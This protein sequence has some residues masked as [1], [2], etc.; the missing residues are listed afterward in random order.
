MMNQDKYA[1][2]FNWTMAIDYIVLY[3]DCNVIALFVVVSLQRPID[4]TSGALNDRHIAV[5]QN[6]MCRFI[7]HRICNKR[8]KYFD[9]ETNVASHESLYCWEVGMPT[10]V[11]DTQTID[12]IWFWNM[13]MWLH[14]DVNNHVIGLWCVVN[15]ELHPISL[16][17]I[18]GGIMIWIMRWVN[19]MC[20]E[21][22]GYWWIKK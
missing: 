22:S 10:Y 2:I 7:H 12:V 21:T 3:C 20:N 1:T 16:F 8:D 17:D 19:T 14:C 18:C 11:H 6:D 13:I 9:S 15:R 4:P 5:I